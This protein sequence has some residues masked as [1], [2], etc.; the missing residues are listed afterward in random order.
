MLCHVTFG[1]FAGITGA[2]MVGK[3]PDSFLSEKVSLS[4][5]SCAAI[6]M[7]FAWMVSY[8]TKNYDYIYL[9]KEAW[10]GLFLFNICAWVSYLMHSL[11]FGIANTESQMRKN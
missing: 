1:H 10:A 8:V 9:L 2:E 3:K 7:V 5:R 6:F 4:I 11:R